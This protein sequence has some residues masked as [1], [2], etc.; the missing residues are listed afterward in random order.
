MPDDDSELEFPPLMWQDE[1]VKPLRTAMPVTNGPAGVAK[2]MEVVRT[3]HPHIAAS[4]DAIWGFAECDAYLQ[5][6]V[7]DGSDHRAG[8][9]VGFKDEV[10]QAILVLSEQHKVTRS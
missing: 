2:S 5:K 1:P 4:L 8:A 6:L 10:F 7:S 9:R 3:H